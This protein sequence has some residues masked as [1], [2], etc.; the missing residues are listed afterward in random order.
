MSLIVCNIPVVVTATVRL[1]DQSELGVPRG[2]LVSTFVKFA[3]RIWSQKETSA[4]TNVTAITLDDSELSS[5]SREPRSSTDMPKDSN[6]TV[7]TTTSGFGKDSW[8]SR[9]ADSY[10][11]V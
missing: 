7:G 2:P 4:T 11:P 8:P 5:R 9:P 3:T 6:T 1:Y 10:N